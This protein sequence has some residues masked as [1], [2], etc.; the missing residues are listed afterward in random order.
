M[1]PCKRQTRPLASSGRT[2]RRTHTRARAHTHTHRRTQHLYR[3]AWPASK[4]LSGKSCSR[5]RRRWRNR[6]R[7]GE[8]RRSDG[9]ATTLR[10]CRGD[11]AAFRG[12][13]AFWTSVRRGGCADRSYPTHSTSRRPRT[14]WERVAR[15]E[16]VAP[17]RPEAGI[18]RVLVWAYFVR[19]KFL[20][21]LAYSDG[22]RASRCS[23]V[24]LSTAQP[25]PAHS[26]RLVSLQA[27]RSLCHS[28]GMHGSRRQQQACVW[29]AASGGRCVR[30]HGYR[31]DLIEINSLEWLPCAACSSAPDVSCIFADPRA[32]GR[33]CA[34][35]VALASHTSH[36]SSSLRHRCAVRA[37]GLGMG[38]PCDSCG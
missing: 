24:A 10:S 23:Q 28:Y 31:C 16:Q 11:L 19:R 21:H 30:Y 33:P 26:R 25:L 34:T 37:A 12:F 2:V 5:R 32:P 3:P 18:G 14:W 8:R 27:A 1:H 17:I 36:G 35:A 13:H 9:K 7:R 15:R 6:S 22:K 20:P 4:L 38:M 29:K